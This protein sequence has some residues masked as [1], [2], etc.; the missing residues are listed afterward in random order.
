MPSIRVVSL[1]QVATILDGI[2]FE[3]IL[4][5]QAKAFHAYSANETQTPQRPTLQTSYH[6]TLIMPARI[7]SLTSVV[8]IVSV[9]KQDSKNGLPGVTIVMDNETGEPR[10]LVNARLLTAVRTAAGSALATRAIF[11]AKKSS[12]TEAELTLVVFGSGAQ[13][14]SHIQLLT[15]VLP[16]INK[17]IIC[18]R[19]LPRAQDLVNEL[20]PQYKNKVDIVAFSISTGESTAPVT[21]NAEQSKE[22]QLKHIVQSANVICTC[23]NTRQPL[24]PGEWVKS[25]TH[26]N[27]VG[28]YTPEMHEIDQTLV[29]RAVTLADARREC[30]EEAGE[31]ILAKKE[32]G[33][34]GIVAELGQL[35]DKNGQFVQLEFPSEFALLSSSGMVGDNK[36]VSI[37]KSVGIAAQDVAITALI[38]DKA[39]E[40]NL[41]TVTEI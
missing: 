20:Q 5:S 12:D 1:E 34:N 19:T 21:T 41:G 10:G 4:T 36:D 31:F 18:N 38:L 3:D 39:E 23:T 37:F 40:M 30:E 35:F 29:K 28:S 22:D 26:L 33:Q 7:D 24:F 32:T 6:S 8:K 11:S 14:K 25:G 17:V 27:M 15:H 13:A 9:P 2:N 16:Q